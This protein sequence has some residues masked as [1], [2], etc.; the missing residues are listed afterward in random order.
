MLNRDELILIIESINAIHDKETKKLLE[1]LHHY[2]YIIDT[3]RELHMKFKKCALHGCKAVRIKRGGTSYEYR[4]INC[5]ELFKCENCKMYF[6]DIHIN[7]CACLI[8]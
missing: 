6:C 2:E 1:E 8:K 7:I 3:C 5:R 4:D